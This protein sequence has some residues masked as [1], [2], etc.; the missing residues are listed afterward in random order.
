MKWRWIWLWTLAMMVAAFLAASPAWAAEFKVTRTDDPTPDGCAP[1]DCSLREAVIA[2]NATPEQDTIN[3]PKGTYTLTIGGNFEDASATGDLDLLEDVTIAGA[4]AHSTIV[5]GG[6]EFDDRIFDVPGTIV[7]DAP[8]I[9]SDAVVDISGV[10]ITGGKNLDGI[11]GGIQNVGTLTLTET[12]VSGNTAGASGGGIRNDFDLTIVRSTLSNNQVTNSEGDPGGLGGGGGI[13]NNGATAITNSTITGNVAG[14]FGGG[15]TNFLSEV[16]QNPPPRGLTLAYVTLDSNSAPVGAN[17]ANDNAFSTAVEGTIVS[18]PQGGGENCTLTVTSEG[19]NLE[20]TS[21]STCGFTPPSDIV[22][23]DPLL[24]PLK[25]NG[26][27]TDTLALLKGSPAIDAVEPGDCPPPET[28]QRGVKRP[29]NGVGKGPA[30]C[31]IGAYERKG[32]KPKKDKPKKGNGGGDGGGGG[33]HQ[34]I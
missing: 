4:G 30:T 12:N 19:N 13:F 26:G 1:N 29:K 34:D 23:E 20:D 7:V 6:P 8:D 25:N 2:A 32:A 28:D 18:N 11:G 24:G 5:T 21:P 14:T 22:G 10:T 17:L 9:P 27:P 15:I 31:D 16:V 3:I 33:F